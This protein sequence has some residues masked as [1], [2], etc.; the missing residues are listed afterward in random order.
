MDSR[1][2]SK[3]LLSCWILNSGA[4]CPLMPWTLSS[5]PAHSGERFP[6]TLDPSAAS[7]SLINSALII[8]AGNRSRWDHKETFDSLLCSGWL[9]RSSTEH[10]RYLE[11]CS[12]CARCFNLPYF[13][14]LACSY[15]W[16]PQEA[17]LKSST[18]FCSMRKKP[19][20]IGWVF[21]GQM[22]HFQNNRWEGLHVLKPRPHQPAT[23]ATVY[24]SRPAESVAI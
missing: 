16:A 10:A 2:G 11:T 14:L 4:V 6:V 3:R 21:Q 9:N 17:V 13:Q 5:C 18:D 7:P 23:T 22:N 12:C 20:H 24:S 8:L 1:K 15:F 19:Q